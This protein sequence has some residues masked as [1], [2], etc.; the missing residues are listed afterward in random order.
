MNE[1]KEENALELLDYG[2]FGRPCFGERVSGDNAIIEE[3]NGFV[4]LGIID[5]LGHGQDA[6]VISVEI[7]KFL[8]KTGQIM[9][10][11]LS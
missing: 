3:R 10:Q 11:K 7:E 4:L 6:N 5:V 8:R 2:S 9:Y 1:K